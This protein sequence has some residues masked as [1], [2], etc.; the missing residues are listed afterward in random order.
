MSRQS[1]TILAKTFTYP[2][3][4]E[5]FLRTGLIKPEP[6]FDQCYACGIDEAGRGPLAGPVFAAA[7]ILPSGYFNNRIKD[8]KLIKPKERELLACEIKEVSLCY[9]IEFVSVEEI[10]RINILK[11]TLTAMAKS[12]ENVVGQMKKLKGED[13]K[14][15]FF[16]DGNTK[17]ATKLSQ[18]TIIKGDNKIRSIA[19]A[20]ILAK[21]ARDKYMLKLDKEYPQYGFS[22]HKGY[23]TKKH[24]ES[25][26]KHGACLAHRKTF[27]GVLQKTI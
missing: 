16:V 25:I 20:S 17:M 15:H 6:F 14:I 11:A 5:I 4:V 3:C 24:L 21:T 8:S 9:A 7:V 22:L 13:V 23:G 10:D 12:A 19:A 2:E 26:K 27:K 1:S 18:D